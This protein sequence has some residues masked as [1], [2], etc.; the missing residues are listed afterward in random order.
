MPTKMAVHWFY[1]GVL[2]IFM[3]GLIAWLSPRPGSTRQWTQVSESVNLKIRDASQWAMKWN[4]EGTG[5]GME[6]N[7]ADRLGESL[8]GGIDGNE[9]NQGQGRPVESGSEGR[10][11]NGDQSGRATQSNQNRGFSPSP[12]NIQWLQWLFWITVIL[13]VIWMIYKNRALLVTLLR[14]WWTALSLWLKQFRSIKPKNQAHGS[15]RRIS[16]ESY[17][18]FKSFINPFSNAS[19]KNWEDARIICYTMEAFQAWLNDQR[20][21]HLPCD[22]AAEQMEQWQ[23]ELPE[24]Y[25]ALHYLYGHY[26]HAGY[27]NAPRSDFSREPLKDLWTWMQGT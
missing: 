5:E 21:P 23:R 12:G 8:D 3:V 25:D 11:N 26:T 22:T 27:G 24:A 9:Q 13:L 6:K 18:K 19:A 15:P 20:I 7:L 17:P 10:P 4:P 14:E 1:S 2:T 16:T